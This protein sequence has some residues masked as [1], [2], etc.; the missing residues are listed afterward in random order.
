[1]SKVHRLQSTLRLAVV[2]TT[3]LLCELG[4]GANTSRFIS[5]AAQTAPAE[6]PVPPIAMDE[7]VWPP[8][9][10]D[11]ILHERVANGWHIGLVIG[12]LESD[13]TMRFAG[14]GTRDRAIQDQSLSA[15]PDAETIF[16][17]GSISKAF[18]GILLAEAERRGE[19]TIETPW[20]E[21]LP[22][23][24][25][26]R[27]GVESGMLW[28]LTT[29][30]ASMPPMP[31]N[32]GAADPA[33]PFA[34]YDAERLYRWVGRFRPTEAPG[35]T[36]TYSNL[37]T[38]LLGQLLAERANMSYEA[39]VAERITA[40]LGLTDLGITL[41][42]EQREREAAPFAGRIPGDR[43]TF[44]ALA[45]AGAL[46]GS[47]RDLLMF[48][49]ANLLAH[50][51]DPLPESFASASAQAAEL[52]E[53]MRRSHAERFRIAPDQFI[54]MGWMC[55]SMDT[56]DA[57][58]HNGG[59]GGYRSFVAFQPETGRAVVVL[60]NSTT[61]VDEIGWRLLDS[62]TPLTD[63]PQLPT[64]T[65]DDLAAYVGRY[66]LTPLATLTVASHALG[67]GD[68]GD[69]AVLSAQIT[70]QG[71]LEILPNAE[72]SDRFAYSLVM[73][74]LVFDRD[75]ETDTI[76]GVTLHQDGREMPMS[77]IIDEP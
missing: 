7:H 77:R 52:A 60:S 1:M 11:T 6:T 19:V 30:T 67:A 28:H 37:G 74:E 34:H 75:P 64:R 68:R 18:T 76:S 5:A 22:E 61:S 39:L 27:D 29:H 63:L 46:R 54:G 4:L 35:T 25:S 42:A 69:L 70:G 24:V 71:P 41:T 47:A 57:W 48:A 38:G 53:S 3:V 43:W 14:Y 9:A 33:D 10:L 56:G 8:V 44:D 16:E 31:S 72:N 66:Q 62:Q 20:R 55:L 40:P 15:T 21:L 59:T 49:Q 73:A 13:G 26:T 65:A 23:G 17:I 2:A 36:F 32:L 58:W 12:R 51:Q 45:G 50:T